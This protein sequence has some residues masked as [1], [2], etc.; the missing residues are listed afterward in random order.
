MSFTA[1][2]PRR[3]IAALACALAIGVAPA[4]ANNTMDVLL[5]GRQLQVTS[6][7]GVTF[8]VTFSSN[9]Q[10]QTSTGSSGAWT[11]T[12]DSLCTT[13]VG[14]TTPNCGQLP[15][16]K[17]LGDSWQTTDGNGNAVTASIV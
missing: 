17:V 7:S 14:A 10:Y 6:A 5:Q 8:T 1:K 15:A 9:G 13:R 11:M 3:T 2:L 12:D 16:G 4:V